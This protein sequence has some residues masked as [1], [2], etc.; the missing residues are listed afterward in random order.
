MFWKCHFIVSYNK[1]QQENIEEIWGTDAEAIS[2]LLS[3]H[4]L[5]WHLEPVRLK[6]LAKKLCVAEVASLPATE[7][8]WASFA[9][10]LL[11][12]WRRCVS[13]LSL[14]FWFHSS[15][16]AA[17]AWFG[18]AWSGRASCLEWHTVISTQR[19]WPL[20]PW[21]TDC[22]A[23]SSSGCS[24]VSACV[25]EPQCSVKLRR[26]LAV[27]PQLIVWP[28]VGHH[29]LELLFLAL[30]SDCTL[31]LLRQTVSEGSVLLWLFLCS[32]GAVGR[33]AFQLLIKNSVCHSC[34]YLCY[35]TA[36][37]FVALIYFTSL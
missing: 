3:T 20:V 12:G 4:T 18:R 33:L 28:I 25:V 14:F 36:T 6:H 32:F 9:R 7:W 16:A 35:R 5:I 37:K 26:G 34:P 22:S 17:A 10:D 1:K 29:S 30:L 31:W 11:T 19:G 15:I 23:G 8:H 24:Y 21:E 13:Y 2:T 27:R